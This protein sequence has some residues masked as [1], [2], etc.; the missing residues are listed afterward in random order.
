MRRRAQ[1]ALAALVLVV[2][3]ST[4]A[5]WGW[6]HNRPPYG[7]EVLAATATLEFASFE[8]AS[9]ALGGVSAPL[10]DDGDQLVLGRVSWRPPPRPQKDTTFWITVLD[11]RSQRKAAVMAAASSRQDKVVLGS[12]GDLRR[13]ADRYPWL[14]GIDG[15]EVD[16][17]W[18]DPGNS[19]FVS[20]S[21]ATPL[22]FVALFPS[23]DTPQRP[24]SAIPTAPVALSDLLVALVH[25]GPDGQVYWA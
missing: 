19:V 6:W 7:P 20:A 21:D 16:G 2:G 13:A 4:Y 25:V 9:T 11:K 8:A 22:T 18:W 15:R 14:S 23:A 10:T 17:Q 5:G 12:G 1:A 3:L 24:E